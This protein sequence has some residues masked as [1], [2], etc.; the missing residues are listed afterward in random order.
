[1][2]MQR[3]VKKFLF[4]VATLCTR[5]FF[6]LKHVNQ[7]P[8]MMLYFPIFSVV[9]CAQ[10]GGSWSPTISSV[11]CELVVCRKP[12][13]LPHGVTEGDSYNYGDFV[14]YSCLPGFSMKVLLIRP[15]V[16]L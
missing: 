2:C 3:F 6:S 9:V 8:E 7:K 13:P 4:T 5:L 11:S 12:P 14:I 10:L 16:L 1:M 15:R